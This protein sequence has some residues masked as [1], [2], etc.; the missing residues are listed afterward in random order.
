MSTDSI[1]SQPRLAVLVST[2]IVGGLIAIYSVAMAAESKVMLSGAQ[3]VPAVTTAAKGNGT[4]TIGDDKTVSGSVTTSGVV[5]TVA[6]IHEGLA[7]KNGPPIIT[8][9]KKGE[10]QWMVPAN[11]KLTDAQYQAYKAGN[12]Y[13]NVHSAAHKGGEIRDQLKP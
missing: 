6:H 7:G 4:I 3:E 2:A 5:G 11:A 8:L 1:F 12:L 10:N 13:V 9:E